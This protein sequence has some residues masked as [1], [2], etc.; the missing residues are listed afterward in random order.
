[1]ILFPAIDLKD[2]RCV[3][4]KRGEMDSATVFNDDPAA[5]ARRSSATDSPGC[6]ASISTAPS[7]GRSANG[8]AIRA[9]RA[10]TRLPIQLGGGIRDMAA[11]EGWLEAGITRVILG[12]AALKNPALVQRGRARL[13]GH[14]SSS[15]PTPRAAR[16]RPKAGRRS[17]S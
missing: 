3:R 6:T 15:A 13:S 9:I 8:E 1:M 17:R 14:G 7:P 5:Q 10:A 11:V 2:G 4:L 16:S 12:T